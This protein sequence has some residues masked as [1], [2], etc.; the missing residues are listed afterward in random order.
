VR[1]PEVSIT[2]VDGTIRRAAHNR[3]HTDKYD[4]SHPEGHSMPSC[5]LT[6]VLTGPPLDIG[7]RENL[8]SAAPVQLLLG[9]IWRFNDLLAI[10]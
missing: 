4:R 7:F 2:V 10:F 6:A 9:V 3:G 5:G 8:G 1:I